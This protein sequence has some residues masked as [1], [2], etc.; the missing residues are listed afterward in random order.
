MPDQE[1]STKHIAA[2]IDIGTI[3]IRMVIAEVGNKNE[4]VIW[5]NFKVGSFRQ[6]C[7]QNGRLSN[8][9]MRQASTFSGILNP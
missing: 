9:A 5:S 3:A 2:V 8:A 1:I 6:G 4:I 7:F